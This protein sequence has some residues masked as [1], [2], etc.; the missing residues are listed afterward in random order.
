VAGGW[1]LAVINSMRS[2]TPL[3]I[4]A[5]SD[6]NFDGNSTD[7]A[8]LIGD[9][10]LD[11]HRPRSQVVSQWFNPKAFSSQTQ[12]RNSFDGTSGRGILDGPG[13]KN[14]DL[15][16]YREFRIAEGK[17][18]LFRTE[19]TNGFNLVNLSNPG[20]SA[21]NTSQIGVITTAG[22]MRQLQLGLKLR[23]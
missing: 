20:T 12:A 6:R 5:G 19:M 14:V 10:Y 2:G 4:T 18:L 1:S 11:P 21:N 8:D 9:P 22:P 3:T 7:R 16:I 15:G 13:L 17:T 23:F